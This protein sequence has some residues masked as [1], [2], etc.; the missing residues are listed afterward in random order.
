VE[1]LDSL[2]Q[3]V[4]MLSLLIRYFLQLQHELWRPDN[5]F[6]EAVNDPW[7]QF[8]SFSSYDIFTQRWLS[9]CKRVLKDTGTIWVIGTYHNIFRI[10]ASMQDLGFWFLNDIIWVKTNPMPFSRRRYE[11]T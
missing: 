8:D 11:C 10:G 7:D 1:I 5:S 3:I 6:V 4:S 2:P 9:A